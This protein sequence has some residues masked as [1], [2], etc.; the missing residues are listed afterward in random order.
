LFFSVTSEQLEAFITQLKQAQTETAI[1][2]FYKTF[3]IRRNHKQFWA[4]YDGFN[5]KHR[6]G[7]PENAGLFDLSRYG[8]HE[9]GR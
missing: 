2:Q 8:N 6:D 3:A 7:H 4:I 9:N 1:T 5:Q